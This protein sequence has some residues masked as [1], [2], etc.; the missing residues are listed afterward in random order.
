MFFFNLMEFD[1]PFVGVI[2]VSRAT[3]RLQYVLKYD[4]IIRTL[5]NH[6]NRDFRKMP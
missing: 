3:T 1:R 5:G 2:L 4:C 6:G